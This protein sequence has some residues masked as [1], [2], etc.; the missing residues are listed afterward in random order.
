VSWKQWRVKSSKSDIFLLSSV[1]AHGH[2]AV[3]AYTQTHT[4]T[5]THTQTHTHPEEHTKTRCSVKNMYTEDFRRNF[6][7]RGFGFLPPV[8]SEGRK[9]WLPGC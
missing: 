6:F 4:H 5:E 8:Y 2:G 3:C 9:E 1:C 7:P